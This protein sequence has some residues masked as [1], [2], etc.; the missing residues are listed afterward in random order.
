MPVSSPS[1]I[2]TADVLAWKFLIIK[3]IG[4]K[5]TMDTT[6]RHIRKAGYENRGE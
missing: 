2:T 5:A 1:S 6:L 4:F 3:V